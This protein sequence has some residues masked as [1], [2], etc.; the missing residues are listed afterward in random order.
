MTI[1]EDSIEESYSGLLYTFLSS[2]INPCYIVTSEYLEL[3]TADERE[4]MPFVSFSLG[5]NT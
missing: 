4:H 5:Y 1:M 3:G 2:E